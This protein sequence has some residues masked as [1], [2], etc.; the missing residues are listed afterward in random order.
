MP[1]PIGLRLG[2]NALALA[3]SP[4]ASIFSRILDFREF[5]LEIGKNLH[6][7]QLRLRVNI[8]AAPAPAPEQCPNREATAPAPAPWCWGIRMLLK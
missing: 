3:Q 6:W 5:F 7:R 1:Q 4:K 8:P 2:E